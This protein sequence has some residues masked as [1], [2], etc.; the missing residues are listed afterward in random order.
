MRR[1]GALVSNL[2]SDNTARDIDVIRSGLGEE[3]LN[4]YGAL[5]GS[6]VGTAYAELFPHRLR[7]LLLDSVVDHSA[8][9]ST[10]L[11]HYTWAHSWPELAQRLAHP[12][13]Q[14]AA[15]PVHQ[16]RS[17][18]P[19]GQRPPRRLLRI[20]ER[21]RGTPADPRL[22]PPHLPG[23]RNRFVRTHR[24]FPRPHRELPDHRQGPGGQRQLPRRMAHRALTTPPGLASAV[25]CWPGPGEVRRG[26]SPALNSVRN[27][28]GG[29]RIHRYSWP[30]GKGGQCRPRWYRSMRAT[31]TWW[32]RLAAT[33]RA[34]SPSRPRSRVSAPAARKTSTVAVWPCQAASCSAV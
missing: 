22:G 9:T 19:A 34:V 14:R 6:V 1:N 31:T 24:L 4:L 23:R 3:K 7:T 13:P 27:G 10:L 32:P 8:D 18:G 33:S 15:P 26:R 21:G 5:Y 11:Q 28:L 16:G 12:G 29:S 30:V 25:P 20:R 2:G 17:Q